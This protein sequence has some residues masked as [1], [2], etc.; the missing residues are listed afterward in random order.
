ME[1]APAFLKLPGEIRNNIYRYLLSTRHVALRSSAC[2]RPEDDRH[3]RH[4]KRQEQWYD[5]R[6]SIL[7]TNRQIC[8]EAS[9]VLRSG[10]VFIMIRF[11]DPL[12]PRAFAPAITLPKNAQ[13]YPQ[14]AATVTLRPTEAVAFGDSIV[15]RLYA[16]QDL[17]STIPYDLLAESTADLNS[18]SFEANVQVLRVNKPTY[19]IAKDERIY[20]TQICDSCRIQTN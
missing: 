19:S 18:I 12:I 7:R 4:I 5:L 9:A 13:L 11:Q 10:N 20:E 8:D 16:F 14:L 3:H 17:E 1:S 6:V 15:E 2:Q